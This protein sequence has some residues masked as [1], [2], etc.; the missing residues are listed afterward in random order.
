[1][2]VK[3]CGMR[4][5][6]DIEY[7]NILKPDY[8][9]FIFAEGFKRQISYDKACELK[10][11]LNKDIL[12][13]GVYINQPIEYIK[14]AIDK[15]IIDVIQL[16]GNED[17][18]YIKKLKELAQVPII[19][20][21]RISE[22]ADYVLYDAKTPGSGNTFDWNTID[23]KK[24]F[25][26]AGGINIDNLDQAKRINPYCIDTSSGVEVDGYK[27]F[28]KMKEFIKKVRL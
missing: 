18:K 20:V 19:N 26:L 16:H 25:F 13:V 3:I 15:R 1:M 4:R 7:A 8:I 6:E 17:D 10:A 21:Y 28:S 2:L 5:K 9:G 24:P 23:K 14:E 22:Y 27:D 12:A 11:L